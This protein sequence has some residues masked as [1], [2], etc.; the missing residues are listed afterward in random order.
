MEINY[1]LLIERLNG[2]DRY[3]QL[4]N[5]INQMQGDSAAKLDYVAAASA[6]NVDRRTIGRYVW[7]LVDRQV[8]TLVKGGKLKINSEIFIEAV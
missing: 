5:Y 6:L 2:L 1:K 8:L 3:A 7:A 4:V